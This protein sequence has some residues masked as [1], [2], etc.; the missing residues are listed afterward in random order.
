M[1]WAELFRE[2]ARCGE[3]LTPRWYMANSAVFV[4][5]VPAF[6]DIGDLSFSEHIGFPFEYGQIDALEFFKRPGV[7][8]SNVTCNPKLVLQIVTENGGFQVDESSE[9]IVIR[10]TEAT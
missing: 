1:R 6:E 4:M 7:G 3:T 9:S 8:I 10:P 5:S 2:F